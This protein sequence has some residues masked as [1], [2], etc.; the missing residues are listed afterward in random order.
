[1]LRMINP[2]WTSRRRKCV[3]WRGCL[4]APPA[5]PECG[6]L[7]GPGRKKSD[8]AIKLRLVV[9]PGPDEAGKGIAINVRGDSP[10]VERAR[11][12]E[13]VVVVLRLGAETVELDRLAHV[14][15]ADDQRLALRGDGLQESVV[16]ITAAVAAARCAARNGE[17]RRDRAGSS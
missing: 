8:D 13:E 11:L 14:V 2:S 1:M 5:A 7:F 4:A 16:A 15:A 17:K 9:R 10:A 6:G 3:G 12:P